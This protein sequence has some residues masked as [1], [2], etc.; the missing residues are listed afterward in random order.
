MAYCT[1]QDLIDRFSERELIQLTDRTNVPVSA[2]DDTV[3]TRALTDAAALADGYLGKVYTLPLATVPPVLTKLVA[4][5][6]RFYL[7]GK[8][9]EKDSPIRTAFNDA[10]AYLRD[11]SRGLVQLIEVTTG[12]TPAAAGGGQ[13]QVIAPPKIF[14]RDSLRNY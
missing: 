14:S 1:K 9:V 13:V 11:V 7:H 6:A 4:D 2:I 8:G 3:V 5:I 12:E 10:V